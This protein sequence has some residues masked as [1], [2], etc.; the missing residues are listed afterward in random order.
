MEKHQLTLEEALA[1]IKKLK[2]LLVEELK[3]NCSS[4]EAYKGKAYIR[5]GD[6]FD[7]CERRF[8]CDTYKLFIIY[9]KDEK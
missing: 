3:S 1:E 5:G 6:S 9:N 7:D 4:C 8:S 2:K